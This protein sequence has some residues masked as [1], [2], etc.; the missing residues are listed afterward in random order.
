MTIRSAFQVCLLLLPMVRRFFYLCILKALLNDPTLCGHYDDAPDFYVFFWQEKIEAISKSH[1]PF[2]RPLFTNM[3][4]VF[5]GCLETPRH[6]QGPSTP[7]GPVNYY[8]RQ[9]SFDLDDAEA[10]SMEADDDERQDRPASPSLSPSPISVP[11]APRKKPPASPALNVQVCHIL[12]NCTFLACS[13]Q[14]AAL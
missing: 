4:H 12:Q 1:P 5:D 9:P 11:S 14:R 3:E 10:A 6:G 13:L 8:I 2:H 7:R